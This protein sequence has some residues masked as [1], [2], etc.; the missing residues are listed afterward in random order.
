MGSLYQLMRKLREK[1]P[2]PWN[3]AQY[4]VNSGSKLCSSL[5]PISSGSSMFLCHMFLCA[6]YATVYLSHGVFC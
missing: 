2:V 3:I 1:D 4:G 5:L 6:M